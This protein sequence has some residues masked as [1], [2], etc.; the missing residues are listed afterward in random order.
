M[1]GILRVYAPGDRYPL[2]PYKFT[3][4]VV[5]RRHIAT[6]HGMRLS[7]IGWRDVQALDRELGLHGVTLATWTHNNKRHNYTLRG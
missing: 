7:G 1:I 3:A 2:S 4:T 6:I 5:I